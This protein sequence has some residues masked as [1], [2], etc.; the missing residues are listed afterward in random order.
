MKQRQSRGFTL[1]EL[2]VVIIIIGVLAGVVGPRFLGRTDQA[3]VSAAQQQIENFSLALDSYQLDN[4]N[5]PSTQQGLD[6]LIKKPSGSPE[7]KGWRGPYLKKKELP[8][9]PWGNA[10]VYTSPGKNNPQEY[11]LV[12]FG[13]DGKEGGEGDD[14]DITNW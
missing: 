3:K 7:P 1:I 10:Y 2:L 14:A 11:D 12:S 13:K 8:T 4:G 5:F 9:D 6:A